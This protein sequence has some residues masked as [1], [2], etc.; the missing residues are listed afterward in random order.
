MPRNTA[1]NS[2]RTALSLLASGGLIS[3]SLA[4]CNGGSTQLDTANALGGNNLGPVGQGGTAGASGTAG[5]SGN[6][7]Q[8]GNL[9]CGPGTQ[10]CGDICVAINVDPA[11]CGSCGKTCQ[12][13]QV[14]SQGQCADNCQGGLAECNGMCIN[15]Q[16][17]PN[18]CGQCGKSCKS[19][20]FC[21]LGTCAASCLGTSVQCGNACVDPKNDPQNCGQC[22]KACQAN[23]VCSNGTCGLNCVGGTTKCGNGCVSTQNDPQHC[24]ACDKACQP[25]QVC[26]NGTCSSTCSGGTTQCGD[27]CVATEVDPAN[28]GGCGKICDP[29]QV[30]SKGT[31]AVSC[32]G[33]TTQCGN[34]CVVTAVDPANCGACDK[35]CQPGQVC[36]NGQCSTVCGGGTSNC[37]NVCVDT[38]TNPKNCGACDKSCQPGQV[39]SQG[40]CGLECTGGT[41]KCGAL[42]ADLIND[43]QNCGTCGKACDVGDVCSGG[44]CGLLCS[45][46]TTKCGVSCVDT[47]NDP[48]NCGGCGVVC[49]STQVCVGSKCANSCGSGTT[50]CGNLCVDTKVD[51]KHCGSCEKSCPALEVCNNGTC[52]TVCSG[53]L[54][55]CGTSCVDTKTNPFNCGG[56]GI[57]C[58]GGGGCVDSKC[59]ACD[60]ATTDCDGDGW[61]ASEGDCC[62]KPGLCGAEPA[63][64]NPGALEVVGNG[65]DDNCNGKTDLFDT[66]DTLPCDNAL[67]SNSS[68]PLDLA[69][70]I[71]VCKT[72]E[73]NP[74]DKKQKTWGL[75]SAEILRA[76]GSPLQDHRAHSIRPS[77]G[78]VSPGT[79]EGSSIL[80][81]S[82]G[83]A[84]DSTQTNPGP[85]GGPGSGN[86]SSNHNPPSTVSLQNGGSSN[87]VKDWFAT[88]NPPLKAANQLPNSPNCAGASSPQANDSVMLRF[89]LRAPT[90]ARAF[91][92]NSYFFSAEYPEFVCT[93]FNDQF[94]ALVDTPNGT[95]SPIP[96]PV[97]KNL[98]TYTQGGK[99]WP[100][101][102]NIANGTS[103]FSV[104]DTQM[105]KPQCWDSDVST[106]SCSLGSDQLTGTGFESANGMGGCTVGGGTF[107]L[108]TAGNVVPGQIVEIRIALWDVGD[109]AFDSLALIDGFKWLS[110][111]TLPGTSD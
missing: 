49:P 51:P 80:V 93:T 70:A 48:T 35:A 44:N 42:C 101:G 32:A 108:T 8:G 68:D 83:I 90:N 24:G 23:E 88:P 12:A 34:Q 36:S 2:L 10:S 6:A 20:E 75:I 19:G 61:L 91:S 66:E 41:S 92:F 39:C 82:S 87:S 30:C 4:A 74:M 77:F 53:G 81:L 25:G 22:Q 45:G 38:S 71:G 15:T 110:Q 109:S 78:N 69:R 79:L 54:T 14:C 18:N 97:D 28:C 59:Q 107:W 16:F 60:S 3:L 31:C 86:V 37:G 17:D 98:L 29:G 111:A 94:I 47:T 104:C 50:L 11:N 105:S 5:S 56:C 1:F 96:N 7:G 62:D 76:D 103:L 40:K 65:I 13:G 64:V 58:T 55:K 43:P 95:P 106:L 46:G 72:T 73:E 26:S 9:A 67:S 33:G 89:R 52:D 102:I 85:N 57:T 21:S 84:A 99:K 63:K 100:I 27:A